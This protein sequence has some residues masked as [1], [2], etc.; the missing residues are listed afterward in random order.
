MP[1]EGCGEEGSIISPLHA[2]AC[3]R[4]SF[5]GD[6]VDDDDG[7]DGDDGADGGNDCDFYFPITCLSAKRLKIK[8][9]PKSER[10]I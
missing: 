1:S 7:G 10:Y 9:N 5:H 8:S 6:L 3:P 4:E 2:W